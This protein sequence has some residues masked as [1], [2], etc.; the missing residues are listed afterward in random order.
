[1]LRAFIIKDK[2]L[3]STLWENKDCPTLTVL[4]ACKVA[5]LFQCDHYQDPGQGPGTYTLLPAVGKIWPIK[6]VYIRVQTHSEGL[7]QHPLS[8]GLEEGRM[9]RMLFTLVL[10]SQTHGNTAESGWA[11]GGTSINPPVSFATTCMCHWMPMI[12]GTE[13]MR[14]RPSWAT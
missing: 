14:S 7:V 4:Q 8:Q 6:N 9:S 11:T 13:A 5:Q 3:S 10:Q 2:I 12:P 1:M